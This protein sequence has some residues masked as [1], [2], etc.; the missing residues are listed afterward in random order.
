MKVQIKIG[1][2]VFCVSED[3]IVLDSGSIVQLITQGYT[4]GWYMVC[5]K[6]S[7]KLFKDL[8]A[9][10]ILYTDAELEE[11][12]KKHYPYPDTKC[13]KFDIP[14]MIKLGYPTEA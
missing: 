4:D 6:L 10:L 9:L 3:D 12:T 14:R 5:P 8:K 2:R 7:K 13:Y 1:R 11:Y